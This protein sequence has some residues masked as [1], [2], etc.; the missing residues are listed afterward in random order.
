MAKATRDQ[1]ESIEASGCHSCY[2]CEVGGCG[3][4]D[5]KAI[6]AELLQYRDARSLFA[7][8]SADEIKEI[9]RDFATMSL[10]AAITNFCRRRRDGER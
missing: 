8:P 9:G 1:L 5:F 3:P 2:K 6:A 7:D 10:P 4:C